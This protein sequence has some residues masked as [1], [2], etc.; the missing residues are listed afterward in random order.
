MAAEFPYK[1]TINDLEGVQY[2][3][4]AVKKYEEEKKLMANQR[5]DKK[6]RSWLSFFKPGTSEASSHSKS[7]DTALNKPP[8]PK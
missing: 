6:G 8:R 4:Q 5:Q 3:L 2:T 1:K 7:N